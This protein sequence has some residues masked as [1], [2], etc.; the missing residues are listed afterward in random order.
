MSSHTIRSTLTKFGMAAAS[1]C[2]ASAVT[3]IPLS[4]FVP[5]IEA[6][7][8]RVRYVPPKNL[9]APKVSSAGAK[10]S[11]GCE[12]SPASCC[13]LSPTS[14]L[15]ALLPDFGLEKAPVPQTI[16]ERPTI[17][18]LVPKVDGIAYFRLHETDKDL[19]RGKRIY[20]TSFAITNEAG[21]ISFQLPEDAPPL[22]LDKIYVWEFL[23]GDLVGEPKVIGGSFRRVA[24]SP[25]LTAQLQTAKTP[26]EKAAIYAESSLWFETVQSLAEAKKTRSGSYMQ[27]REVTT[28]W[29]ELLNA[30]KLERV[31]PFTFLK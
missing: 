9:D 4:L 28:E 24:S 19:N 22:A 21:I 29:R 31:L 7:T 5:T 10:R 16:A 18:F 11:A 14:C 17:Y 13:E 25:E 23:I 15:I 30:A 6:Q 26:V 12:G 20:R 3:I 8:R 1:L 2:I 27:T